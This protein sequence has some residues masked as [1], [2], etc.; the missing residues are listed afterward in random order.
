LTIEVEAMMSPT[1][2]FE[3]ALT[4]DQGSRW[5]KPKPVYL[6][7]GRAQ[8]LAREL[9]NATGFAPDVV[10]DEEEVTLRKG[11]ADPELGYRDRC[12]IETALAVVGLV[13]RL[14]YGGEAIHD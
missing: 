14:W 6:T 5:F 7:K 9:M 3:V 4:V 1:G 8:Q 12:E 11:L 2:E 10:L 13:R